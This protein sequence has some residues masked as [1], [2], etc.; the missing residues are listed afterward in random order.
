V[1]T[2][3]HRPPLD[4][5]PLSTQI[6]PEVLEDLVSGPVGRRENLSVTFQF[7]GCTIVVTPT[8]IRVHAGTGANG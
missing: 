2:V 7:E 1:S 5:E 6:D 8:A 3:L 4:L